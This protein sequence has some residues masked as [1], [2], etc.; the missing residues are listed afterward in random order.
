M[1]FSSKEIAEVYEADK[2]RYGEQTETAAVQDG[3]HVTPKEPFR[4]EDNHLLPNQYKAEFDRLGID[5]D[6][7]TVTQ[8]RDGH[9]GTFHAYDRETGSR[10][11]EFTDLFETAKAENREVTREEVL[12]VLEDVVARHGLEHA[13]VH[14]YRN[15]A[16]ATSLNDLYLSEPPPPE[17]VTAPE[18]PAPADADKS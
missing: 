6:R 16:V 14:P 8:D 9:Q 10:N 4:L 11:P 12:G 2:N 1:A 7:Y 15:D 17:P 13:E 5:N 18:P 3:A